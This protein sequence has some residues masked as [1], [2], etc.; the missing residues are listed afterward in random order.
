MLSTALLRG[1]SALHT[2]F[3]VDPDEEYKETGMFLK[4]YRCSFSQSVSFS[5]DFKYN[6]FKEFK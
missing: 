4:Q 5:S 2:Q 1:K 6:A 3:P